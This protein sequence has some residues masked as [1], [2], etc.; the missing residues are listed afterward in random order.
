MRERIRDYLAYRSIRRVYETG[1]VPS[2][3][4]VPVYLKNNGYYLIFTKR[5]DTV[6]HH[7]GQISFP[8]GRYEESDRT[9]QTTALRECEEEIGLPADMVEIVGELDSVVT[10]TSS[11]VVTP[12]V[13]FV[14]YPFSLK[15]HPAEIDCTIEIPI[16]KLMEQLNHLNDEKKGNET[17]SRTYSYTYTGHVI[18]GAT[19]R[20]LTQFLEIWMAFKAM[21]D[22]REIL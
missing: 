3:V 17:T 10:V 2:A 6:Q 8:G 13:G 19:A 18:W 14:T 5:T 7:K 15:C 20:I 21:P 12:F 11:Y 4:L 1:R 22:Y 9:L 16:T